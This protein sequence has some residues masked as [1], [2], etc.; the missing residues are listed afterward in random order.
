MG[1]VGIDDVCVIVVVFPDFVLA[2]GVVVE[3]AQH[4]VVT[5]IVADGLLIVD[6]V[7]Q[8]D[9][10]VGKLLPLCRR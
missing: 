5:A 9:D 10:V 3:G 7:P 4:G 2:A 1:A 6:D 8:A